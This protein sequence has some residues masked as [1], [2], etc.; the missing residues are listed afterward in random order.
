[1]SIDNDHSTKTGTPDYINN[2]IT[3]STYGYSIHT[4]IH[5][6]PCG[7]CTMLNRVCPM[8]HNYQITWT[9]HPQVTCEAKA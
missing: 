7:Y 4:C 8:D 3:G 9:T 1:M 5:K 6:L 2:D